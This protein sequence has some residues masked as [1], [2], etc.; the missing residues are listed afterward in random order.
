MAKYAYPAIFTIEETGL[1]SVSFPDL[2][3]CYSG[4]D[5][6]PEALEMAADALC[7][8]LYDMEETGAAI[9]AASKPQSVTVPENSF[10]SMVLCDTLEYRKYFDNR[11][12][13]K[14]LTIPAWLNTIAER[15]NVNFSAILQ[16]ALMQYLNVEKR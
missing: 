2:E 13:K 9:P 12:V 10:V 16:Q 14:T 5:N 15:S 1:V 7:L 11:A 3:N 4:G 6:I 8:V